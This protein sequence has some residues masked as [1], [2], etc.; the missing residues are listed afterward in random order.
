MWKILPYN[1]ILCTGINILYGVYRILSYILPTKVVKQDIIKPVSHIENKI[2][3]RLQ[4]L[5]GHARLSLEFKFGSNQP[6]HD[7]KGVAVWLQTQHFFGPVCPHPE[8]AIV[9]D[10]QYGHLFI[11]LAG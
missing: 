4:S 5:H 8:V 2:C 7:V 1:D 3:I 6:L 9:I 11:A 10:T